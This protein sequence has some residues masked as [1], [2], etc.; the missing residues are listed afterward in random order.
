MAT[1]QG[2][3]DSRAVHRN[4]RF[5]ATGTLHMDGA[6]HEFLPRATRST[7]KHAIAI[8]R[9]LLDSLGHPLRPFRLADELVDREIMFLHW[10][11][12]SVGLVV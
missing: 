11:T 2:T 6:C 5:F 1:K 12:L 4:E 9:Y 3:W 7:N 8:I 10:L